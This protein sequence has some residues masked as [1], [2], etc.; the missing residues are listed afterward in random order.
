[1]LTERI[2]ELKLQLRMVQAQLSV[3]RG[4]AKGIKLKWK[5]EENTPRKISNSY[6]G[7]MAAAVDENCTY[8]IEG[9][10]V[11]MY[12]VNTLAWSQLPD[13]ECRGC[14][15]AIVNG[16]LTLIG[17][18]M[19]LWTSPTNSSVSLGKGTLQSGQRNSHPCK[20]NNMEHVYSA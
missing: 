18:I 2:S 19:V 4:G 3:A 15:V 8:V 10:E 5:K 1:M 16:L 13:S 12:N 14:A 9:K 6:C 20:L 7:E 17:G 11:Y